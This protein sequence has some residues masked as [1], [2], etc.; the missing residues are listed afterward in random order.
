MK[1]FQYHFSRWVTLNDRFGT[2]L[3][4]SWLVHHSIRGGD[5]IIHCLLN[6]A[7][8]FF[9]FSGVFGLRCYQLRHLSEVS[10][11]DFTILSLP[12]G[13][14][15]KVCYSELTDAELCGEDD[16]EERK[17]KQRRWDQWP[18]LLVLC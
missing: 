5:A 6:V 11:Q 12:H 18:A 7:M 9:F 13:A 10:D 8:H 3:M 15:C 17:R 16:G 2:Q 1:L 4:K 14:L